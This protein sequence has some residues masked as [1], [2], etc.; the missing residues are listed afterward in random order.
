MNQQQQ[1]AI[2][3]LREENRILREQLGGRRL[4]LN[5]DQRRRLASK[6]KRLGRKML[7]AVATIVT[8][9]TL[10]AWHRKLIAEKYDGCSRR[11]PGR[12]KTLSKIEALVV[13]LATENRD[14]GY[15]RIL[16]ALGNLGHGIGRGT[17]ANILERN[18]IEPAPERKRKTTWKEFL[19]SAGIKP[20]WSSG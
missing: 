7:A 20:A 17:V 2:D 13:K 8:P 10:L 4:R 18:G 15:R 3:Y 6:A 9:E 5:D 16:G 12:P 11:G 19:V 14:W 1:D